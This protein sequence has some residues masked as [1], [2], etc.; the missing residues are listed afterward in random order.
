MKNSFVSFSFL[1]ES[2][3]G[4]IKT[5]GLLHDEDSDSMFSDSNWRVS[6]FSILILCYYEDLILFWETFDYLILMCLGGVI[7]IPIKHG[8]NI[9]AYM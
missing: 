9:H 3:E 7:I 5:S 4:L 8:S 2:S 6:G 1:T